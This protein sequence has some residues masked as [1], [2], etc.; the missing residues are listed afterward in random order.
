MKP[1]DNARPR[2]IIRMPVGFVDAAEVK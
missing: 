1:L 2:L